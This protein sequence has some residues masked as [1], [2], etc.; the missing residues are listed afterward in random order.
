MEQDD[1]ASGLGNDISRRSFLGRGAL[2]VGAMGLYLAG[3]GG[4]GGGSGGGGASTS[5][6]VGRAFS[7]GPPTGG[8]PIRGGTLRVGYITG[9]PAESINL[10]TAGLVGTGDFSRAYALYDGL[11][12]PTPGGT[13]GPA[14]ATSWETNSNATLW[15]FHLR[16]GVVFHNGKTFTA[17][18]VVYTLQHLW[19]SPKNIYNTALA[20]MIDFPRVRKLDAYTVQVPL[21][22][23]IAQFP[24]TLCLPQAY[25]GQAGTT[26]WGDGNG[27]GPFTLE[28]F[29]PGVESVFGA[30][31]NYWQHGRP[32]VDKLII[33]T[34]Y[35][36]EAD[37]L[38]A[39]L[40]GNID[41][42]PGP[43]PALAAANAGSGRLVIGNQ[44]GPGFIDLNMRVDKGIFLDE[45]VRKAFHL[46][47]ARQ[48]YVT[49]AWN[50]YATIG[51]DAPGNTNQF[52]ASDLV[53]T[54]DP[55]QARAL[56]KA[57]GHDGLSITLATSPVVPGMTQTATLFK[58]QALAA[59][60]N[61][62]LQVF[63]TS[64]YL[65]PST[66]FFSRTF[67]LE[68]Y[69]TGENSLAAYYVT[70][71]IK[72][73]IYNLSHWGEGPVNYGPNNSLLFDA[74]RETNSTKASQKWHAVQ[75]ID[76][77]SGAFIIPANNNWIDAYAPH[78][79]GVQTTP[80]LQCGNFNFSGAWLTH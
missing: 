17:D 71:C 67:D 70:S 34:R 78:V 60:V 52:H 77:V 46:I 57:A 14:L 2:G 65:T 62:S 7:P 74:L 8:T 24:S 20:T 68:F 29:R 79:R 53:S 19:A 58:E 66:G 41:I 54:H 55:Q 50:G 33:D 23:G 28:S 10:Y 75:E 16:Q 49:D 5:A 42:V 6:Q 32:Y 3:C 56:L 48:Q 1:L 18:D 59:G 69:T 12:V 45:R 38:N 21:K 11:V 40:A 26:N 76:H 73:G 22:L 4:G 51:N 39:L 61:V 31:K 80:V 9:G 25:I 35:T 27:T 63:P 15:T 72:G 30:N 64:T 37:R 47:P 43:D 36:T 44:P 13:V